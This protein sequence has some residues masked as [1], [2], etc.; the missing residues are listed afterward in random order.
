M[1]H[2][3]MIKIKRKI[4][5]QVYLTYTFPFC[6]FKKFSAEFLNWIICRRQYVHQVHVSIVVTI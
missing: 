6:L 2:C 3:L 4:Y 1:F 5:K